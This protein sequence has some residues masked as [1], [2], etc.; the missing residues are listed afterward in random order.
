MARTIVFQCLGIH[1]PT[2]NRP[3][4]SRSGFNGCREL[5]KGSGFLFRSVST[6]SG[7][8]IACVCL[9]N[10]VLALYNSVTDK[11]VTLNSCERVTTQN[12]QAVTLRRCK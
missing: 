2:L 4:A 9:N 11:G 6:F 3:S 1:P 5:D 8:I 7:N 12:T 10:Q